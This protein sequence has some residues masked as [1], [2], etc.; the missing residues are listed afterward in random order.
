VLLTTAPPEGLLLSNSEPKLVQGV[1]NT[2][3]SAAPEEVA[4]S[5]AEARI[6]ELSF[7]DIS[8]ATEVYVPVDP[9]E[10]E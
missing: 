2:S 7:I 6:L 3:S 5:T 8:N 1:E 9:P 10:D 4:N